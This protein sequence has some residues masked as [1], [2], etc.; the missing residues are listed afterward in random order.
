MDVNT[1]FLKGKLEEDVLWRYFKDLKAMAIHG[2]QVEMG[3]I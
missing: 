2:L 1:T 3:T